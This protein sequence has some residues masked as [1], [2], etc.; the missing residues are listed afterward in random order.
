MDPYVVLTVPRGKTDSGVC[1]DGESS[2]TWNE[3]MMLH[4]L[5]CVFSPSFFLS[6]FAALPLF[7]YARPPPPP[8]FTP[9][10]PTR[11]FP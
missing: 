10:H 2:P 3:K 1:K 7:L 6:C 9:P 8:P 11:H 4:V 5:A